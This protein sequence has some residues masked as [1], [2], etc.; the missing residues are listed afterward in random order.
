MLKIVVFDGGCGGE[1]VADYLTEELGVVEVIRVIER[2]SS[3]YEKQT[4]AELNLLVEQRLKSYI[5]EVDVIVLGGYV[6]SLAL[7]YLQAKYPTQKFVGVG[8]NYYRILRS[9]AYPARITVLMNEALLKSDFCEELRVNLPFSIL[10]VPD[11]TGWGELAAVDGLTTT[12]MRTE[13]ETYFALPPARKVKVLRE[14]P[15]KSILETVAGEKYATTTMVAAATQVAVRRVPEAQRLIPSDV[16]L[17]LNT[18]L[19]GLK[20]EIE[21]V[22]GYRVRVM[23]FRKKLLHDVCIALN[24]LGADGE[25]SK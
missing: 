3:F 25:R 20:R 19:W 10:A 1:I 5:G 18:C 24:L 16:V 2:R 15:H 12:M 9:A 17:I 21:D 14:K 6:V 13:L 11:C 8:V 23:E 7:G 4:R 22:F